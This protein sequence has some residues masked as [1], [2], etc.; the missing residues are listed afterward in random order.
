MSVEW[1]SSPKI[2]RGLVVHS[3]PWMSLWSVRCAAQAN[4][5]RMQLKWTVLCWSEHDTSRRQATHSWPHRSDA[6]WSS[7]SRRAV[8]GARKQCTWFDSLPSPAHGM[9]HGTCH[10]K[11]RGLGSDAGHACWPLHAQSPSQP[12]WWS[13]P[14][15][16]TLGATQAARHQ[17]SLICWRRIRGSLSEAP[18]DTIV[19]FHLCPKKW[20]RFF[21]VAHVHTCPCVLLRFP[22]PRATRSTPSHGRKC[23]PSASPSL[24]SP[25]SRESP[26]AAPTRP[27]PSRVCTVRAVHC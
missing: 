2:F 23:V 3:L 15:G 26:V 10:A 6:D 7:P 21:S 12:P 11:S 18:L 19:S 17:D 1:R 22:C 13:H 16:A 20:Q 14:S 9:S 25:P 27:D 5:N 4:H 8:A 24:D